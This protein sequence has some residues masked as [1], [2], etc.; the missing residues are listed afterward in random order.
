MALKQWT[1]WVIR[2]A[3]IIII[4]FGIVYATD[5]AIRL[6][7]KSFCLSHEFGEDCPMDKCYS[8]YCPLMSGSK[9]EC[10]PEGIFS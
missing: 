10:C 3:V 5:F 2:I 1:I 7:N 8:G 4:I 9:S 6:K